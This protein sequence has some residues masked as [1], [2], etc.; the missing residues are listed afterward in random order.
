MYI[1][2]LYIFNVKYDIYYNEI[3]LICGFMVFVGS[4]LKFYRVW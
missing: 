2:V 1:N 4:M 3:F